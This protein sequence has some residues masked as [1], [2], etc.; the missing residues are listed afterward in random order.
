MDSNESQNNVVGDLDAPPADASTTLNYANESN[1]KGDKPSEDV[2]ESTAMDIVPAPSSITNSTTDTNK[3][4]ST[5][6]KQTYEDDLWGDITPSKGN[7]S[8]HKKADDGWGKNQAALQDKPSDS[9]P[10]GNA[11]V[12]SGWDSPTPVKSPQNN[13]NT[14]GGWGNATDKPSGTSSF[15]SGWT[16]DR[17]PESRSSDNGWADRSPKKQGGWGP[18]RWGGDNP[19]SNQLLPPLGRSAPGP[20]GRQVRRSWAAPYPNR[21]QS[22]SQDQNQWSQPEPPAPEQPPSDSLVTFGNITQAVSRLEITARSATADEDTM[23]S[24]V[25]KHIQQ[26]VRISYE[27]SSTRGR[28]KTASMTYATRR[29]QYTTRIARAK[30]EEQRISIEAEL[31]A[32]KTQMTQEEQQLEFIIKMFETNFETEMGNLISTISLHVTEKTQT[33]VLDLL[34]TIGGPPCNVPN[35]LEKAL[36]TAAPQLLKEHMART[37]QNHR[38]LEMKIAVMNSTMKVTLDIDIS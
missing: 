13:S 27:L 23:K 5:R 7:S 35:V 4:T 9:Q 11:A 20:T 18:N 22:L 3:D 33:A 28:L 30:N 32:F 2:Q 16:S 6:A 34:R 17:P 29:L 10:S 21:S 31:A 26:L 37:E 38:E 19:S 24:A 36:L 15:S 8:Q 1:E 14:S 25:M 12:L